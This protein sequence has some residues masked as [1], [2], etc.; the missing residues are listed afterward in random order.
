VPCSA[1]WRPASGLLVFFALLL[2]SGNAV[3]HSPGQCATLSAARSDA[4][5][6]QAQIA[7]RVQPGSTTPTL[8]NEL[9]ETLTV[10]MRVPKPLSLAEECAL[11]PH[12]QFN[13]CNICPE[14]IVVPSGEFLMGSPESEEGRSDDESPQHKVSFA[15]PF[16]V[17]R[18]AVTFAEW[19]ACVADRGCR[20]HYPGDRGWGRGRQPVINIWWEDA[21]AY[22]QWLSQKTG[23]RYRLLSEAEREYVTR[24]G[25][26]TPFW[27][28]TSISTDQANYDGS[29]RYPFTGGIKGEFRE[30][31]LPVDFFEPN[32]WGL[33]QVHGNV[34]EWV[35]DCWHTNYQGAPSDGSA[36]VRVDCGRRMLRGGDWNS[37]PWHLRSA[38]RGALASGLVFLPAI[39]MRIARPLAP[40]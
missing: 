18:F 34:S 16:A 20:N 11:K 40:R 15:M 28:G 13:E 12:D 39:G 2:H 32:P 5:L 4:G 36:W 29:F 7:Q 17:G 21:I 25:T 6:E 23:K 31:T 24:A 9:S 35:E 1:I 37:A 3:A 22:V 19:D 27:W 30:K 38:S 26:T 14:M 8:I 33:H 10:D